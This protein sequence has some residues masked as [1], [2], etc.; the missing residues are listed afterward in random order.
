MT[1]LITIARREEALRRGSDQGPGRRDLVVREGEFVAIM[2]PL[3]PAS[4]PC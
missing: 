3:A 1:D 4:P 2:G